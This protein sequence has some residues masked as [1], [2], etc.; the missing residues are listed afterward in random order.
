[1]RRSAIKEGIVIDQVLYALTDMD[2]AGTSLV[3]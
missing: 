1:M 2:F 3:T